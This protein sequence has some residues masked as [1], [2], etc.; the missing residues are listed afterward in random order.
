MSAPLQVGDYV[1]WD[2]EMVDG[3]H[4]ARWAEGE[5]VSFHNQY[6][7]L[8]IS[9]SSDPNFSAASN[10]HPRLLR[11][12]QRPASA[13]PRPVLHVG[14]TVRWW[15]D[16]HDDDEAV[17]F[18]ADRSVDGVI[19]ETNGRY[20]RQLYVTA[21]NNWRGT[22]ALLNWPSV[23]TLYDTTVSP[24]VIRACPAAAERRGRGDPG[25]E[26]FARLGCESRKIDTSV[27]PVSVCV[28]CPTCGR[29]GACDMTRHAIRE[30]RDLM[31]VEYDGVKL[32]DLLRIDAKLRRDE[33]PPAWGCELTAAQRAAV[34]AHW[35]AQLRA[36]V[37][38]SKESERRR[39]VLDTEGDE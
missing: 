15:P 35:S 17:A 9:R 25:D 27:G 16:L 5:V 37:A 32:R 7:H 6:V 24:G 18:T 20:V 19:V 14:D 38:A 10:F 22:R 3:G 11:R 1:R 33:S 31:D 26:I 28:P 34:S 29:R 13:E 2:G 8:K 36:K 23:G 12:C 39:V 4:T 21:V 30:A